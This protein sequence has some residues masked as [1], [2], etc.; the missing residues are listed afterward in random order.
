MLQ[1][2]RGMSTSHNF[3]IINLELRL[4]P[5]KMLLLS[6]GNIALQRDQ[7]MKARMLAVKKNR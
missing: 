4:L 6:S 1:F 7:I 2:L 5:L 3:K